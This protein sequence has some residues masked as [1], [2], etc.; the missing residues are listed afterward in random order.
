V[1]FPIG[2]LN[3]SAS[4]TPKRA[5]S[6][7]TDDA[8]ETQRLVHELRVHQIELEVQNEELRRVR[9]ELEQLVAARTA[10]LREALQRA[11]R[12]NASKTHFL[13]TLSHEI[14]TPLN[15][16]S[17]LTHLLLGDEVTAVQREHLE[18]IHAAS[19]HLTGVIAGVLDLAKIEAG[20]LQLEPTDFELA[21]VLRGLQQQ[22]ENPARERRLHFRT[23]VDGVPAR[24]RGDPTRLTQALLN[25]LGNAIKFT[26]AGSITLRAF[27][28]DEDDA[29][30]EVRFEVEDTGCG[31]DVREQGRLFRRFVQAGHDVPQRQHGTGLGLSIT[32]EFAELMG[33]TVG[34]R[35]T[36]GVG[37]TFW[38]T[39][40][41][42]RA[43]S[44]MTVA[45][46]A[47]DSACAALR[48]EH[49]GARVLLADD[50]AVSR[51]VGRLMLAQAGLVADV[52]VNGAEALRLATQNEYAVI[53]LDVQMPVL[54]GMAVARALRKLPGTARTPL[55]ALTAQAFEED[56]QACLRA[57][58]SE[59]LTKP[60]RPERLYEVLLAWLARPPSS[61]DAGALGRRSAYPLQ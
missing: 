48:A 49:A 6:T 47:S 2:T 19:N 10:E 21:T 26:A 4:P 53:L 54:D 5:G 39:A 23:V 18:Q 51:T 22:V 43:R 17:G 36:P 1:S 46:G 33:G 11:E 52:A 50:D 9:A 30:V 60:V 12:A 31:I 13:A 27:V 32:R 57:G 3:A 38:L 59:H 8:L 45:A 14:R 44:S 35:S 7:A 56:R 16:I 61:V 55:V 24:L 34:V 42:G 25:Y 37:S 58:M 40:R 29:N 28:V 41:F 20:V 15:S